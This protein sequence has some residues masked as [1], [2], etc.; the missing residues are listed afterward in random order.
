M[1][2]STLTQEEITYISEK[3]GQSDSTIK[4]SLK[5]LWSASNK[6]N[7]ESDNTSA[8]KF[9]KVDDILEELKENWCYYESLRDLVRNEITLEE[10]YSYFDN[11][12]DDAIDAWLKGFSGKEHR[13]IFEMVT[14]FVRLVL[15]IGECA[16]AFE[17]AF[18][19]ANIFS[20]IDKTVFIFDNM[21]VKRYE[22]GESHK[23][24]SLMG[25]MMV[26]EKTGKQFPLLGN[27]S[28]LS[29]PFASQEK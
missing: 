9:S 26:S 16:E 5:I 18:A 7:E 2:N 25:T 23:K 17:I 12:P 28:S 3:V 29:I 24:S 8:N 19:F 20:E 22:S 15:N 21:Y 1:K 14:D 10:A 11:L 27:D 13:Y 4:E 6:E